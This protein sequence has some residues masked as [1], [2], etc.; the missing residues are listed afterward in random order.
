MSYLESYG[1][2][3]GAYMFN[4]GL[5]ALT[6]LGK[7]GPMCDFFYENNIDSDHA[8]GMLLLDLGLGIGIM[9]D[10]GV[11]AGFLLD[12]FGLNFEELLEHITTHIFRPTSND[13]YETALQTFQEIVVIDDFDGNIVVQWNASAG[14]TV[15]E[16]L[17]NRFSINSEL[18]GTKSLNWTT[19]NAENVARNCSN[20]PLSLREDDILSFYIDTDNHTRLNG[21]M[22]ISFIDSNSREMTSSAI[23]IETTSYGSWQEVILSLNST[24]FIIEQGFNINSIEAINFTYS[25]SEEVSI[26]LDY[27]CSYSL[28]TYDWHQYFTDTLQITNALINWFLSYVFQGTGYLEGMTTDFIISDWTVNTSRTPFWN[29]LDMCGTATPTNNHLTGA[30]WILKLWGVPDPYERLVSILG[31]GEL[32]GPDPPKAAQEIYQYTFTLSLMMGYIPLALISYKVIKKEIIKRRTL[33]GKI[34]KPKME[35]KRR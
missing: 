23:N 6:L 4:N 16:E 26:Y 5:D 30:S 22:V 18:I 33:N 24:D 3:L 2:S 31:A 11:S 25:G 9:A 13:I 32:L 20:S 17:T 8:I 27:L 21:N 19:Y 28:D 14:G 34:S 1:V 10:S 35:K 29:F 12:L 15:N 7:F